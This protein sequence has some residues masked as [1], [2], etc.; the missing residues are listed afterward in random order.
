MAI[1]MTHSSAVG[2]DLAGSVYSDLFGL[3]ERDGI[4]RSPLASYSGRGSLMGWLRTT[5]AQR[6][7]DRHRSTHRENPLEGDFAAVVPEPA[8]P[9][10]SLSKLDSAVT[11]ILKTLAAEERFLLSTYFLDGNT[12]LQI[13]RLLRVHEATVS[14]KLKRLTADLRKRL[15]KELERSGMSRRA[16]EEALGTDPRD[17]SLNLRNLLQTS[18]NSTFYRQAGP[19][20]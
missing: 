8:P 2:E 3:T 14:R 12:L 18:G 19:A 20:S 1:A 17:I 5:L 4:R 9:A 7:V 15:L 16:A 10:A 11:A 13:A 6:H